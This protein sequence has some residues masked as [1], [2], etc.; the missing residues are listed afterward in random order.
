MI[1]YVE[2]IKNKEF[3]NLA[4]TL[5]AI[6]P[7]FAYVMLKRALDQQHPFLH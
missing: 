2:S 7:I 1:Q 4:T 3:A 5:A 6:V